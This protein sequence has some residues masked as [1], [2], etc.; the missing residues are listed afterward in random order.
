VFR[1]GS[2]LD[3]KESESLKITYRNYEEKSHK[4]I[5]FRLVLK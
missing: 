1:G 4:T 3:D 5:G 2:F